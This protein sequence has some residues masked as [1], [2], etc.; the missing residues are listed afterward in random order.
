MSNLQNVLDVPVLYFNLDYSQGWGILLPHLAKLKQVEILTAASAVAALH[1]GKFSEART[2]L[3][4]A[5]TLVRHYQVEPLTISHLVHISMAQIA[6]AATWEFLQSDRWTDGE[7]AELQSDWQELEFFDS[8]EASFNM[9][10]ALAID[11]MQTVRKSYAQLMTATFSGTTGSPSGFFNDPAQTLKELYSH[12]RYW[13]WRSTWSYEEEL[14]S[15]ENSEATLK[16]IHRT[17]LSGAFAPALKELD[18]SIAQINKLH[19]NAAR[20]FMFVGQGGDEWRGTSLLKFADAEVGRRLLVTAIALKRYQLRH[21]NYPADLKALIPEFLRQVP[22]DLMDGQPLRYHRKPDGKFLL[23]SV[24]EDGEDN[25]GDAAEIAGSKSK[26][27]LKGHDAVWPQPAAAEEIAAY[28]KKNP[29]VPPRANQ[30]LIHAGPKGTNSPAST[31]A[32]GR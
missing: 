6:I 2:N 26:G 10:R 14:S 8:S 21:G 3:H 18:A 19:T 7:L 24:G 15:L 9:E 29:T 27:W 12:Y 1:E 30:A 11:F 5:M 20:H 31:N 22:I 4:N 23:Y 16:A 25:G 28:F 32:T 13:S 17:E